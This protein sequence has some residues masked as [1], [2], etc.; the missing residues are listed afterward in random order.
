LIFKKTYILFLLAFIF[1]IT[2]SYTTTLQAQQII[3]KQ[4]ST[5]SLSKQFKLKIVENPTGAIEFTIPNYSDFR[6]K[7]A[8]VLSG[9]G[10]RGFAQIGVLKEFEQADIPI[11]YIVGT[12]IGSVVGGLTA[13]GYSP[14]ELDSIAR[15]TNWSELRKLPKNLVEKIYS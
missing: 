14:T 12:S 7:L 6:A 13:V 10:A 9:G 1:H 4:D 2:Q 15:F 3:Q 11:D 5:F 8:L